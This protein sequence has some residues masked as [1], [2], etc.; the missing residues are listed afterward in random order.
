M[1]L[2]VYDLECLSNLFTYTGYVPKENK[3]YQFCI[4]RWKNELNNL[5]EH[6]HRDK[7][8]QVGYNNKG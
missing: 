7:L 4:C 5:L 1:T 6:L 3:Y 2:E 8:I